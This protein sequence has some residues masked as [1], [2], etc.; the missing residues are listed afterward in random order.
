MISI[1]LQECFSAGCLLLAWFVIDLITADSLSL[2]PLVRMG[3]DASLFVAGLSPKAAASLKKTE[4]LP[5][6]SP[7]ESL[8][9]GQVA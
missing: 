7:T 8:L 2:D 3:K 4:E 9:P 5:A 6:A 1:V